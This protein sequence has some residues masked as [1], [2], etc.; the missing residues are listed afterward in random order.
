MENNEVLVEEV[1]NNGVIEEGVQDVVENV[2]TDSR[3]ELDKSIAAIGIGFALAAGVWG[4]KKIV[5]PKVK[6]FLADRKNKK[7]EETDN[8]IEVEFEDMEKTENEEDTTNS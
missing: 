4:V 3:S 7:K 8:V 1:L 6:K 2:S 5:Q